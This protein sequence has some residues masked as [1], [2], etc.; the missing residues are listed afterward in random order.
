MRQ[1]FGEN[2]TP[3]S[4]KIEGFL[5]LAGFRPQNRVKTKTKKLKRSSPQFGSCI[6]SRI[7]SNYQLL[8]RLHVQDAFFSGRRQYRRQSKRSNWALAESGGGALK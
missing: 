6:F 3:N 7:F 5:L 1:Q 8:F 2:F 4:E